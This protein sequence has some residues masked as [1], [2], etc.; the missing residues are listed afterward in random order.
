MIIMCTV[1]S[2]SECETPIYLLK[3]EAECEGS[4][5]L[6]DRKVRENEI[7]FISDKVCEE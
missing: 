1:R 4:A 5:L 3:H 6:H 2:E 7:K